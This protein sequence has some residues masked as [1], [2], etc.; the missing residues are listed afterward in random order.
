MALPPSNSPKALA[1]EVVSLEM[2]LPKLEKLK[3]YLGRCFR[4]LIPQLSI[5]KSFDDVMEVSQ[6]PLLTVYLLT[7]S[8]LSYLSPALKL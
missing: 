5:A 2:P 7:V 4:E 1:H 6:I 3:K 8:S